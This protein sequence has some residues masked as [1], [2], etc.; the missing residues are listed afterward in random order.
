MRPLP[1]RYN[2]LQPKILAD[3]CFETYFILS[4]RQLY[5]HPDCDRSKFT[6]MKR[7]VNQLVYHRVREY[8][9]PSKQLHCT[10]Q[11]PLKVLV[12]V[13][14][15][16]LSFK[17]TQSQSQRRTQTVQFL[18]ILIFCWSQKYAL[19]EHAVPNFL[20]LITKKVLDHC[21]Q[22]RSPLLCLPGLTVRVNR[23]NLDIRVGWLFFGQPSW[24]INV[25]R[26]PITETRS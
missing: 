6:K 22:G 15:T 9:S 3:I 21:V 20:W 1:T 23:Q 26:F 25:G 19:G 16:N 7:S 8:P 12:F 5:P 14:R 24:H 2:P 4:N 11:W 17:Y 18:K 13:K 10:A